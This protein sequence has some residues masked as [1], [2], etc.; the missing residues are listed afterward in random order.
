MNGPLMLL[1]LHIA[2]QTQAKDCR[3]KPPASFQHVPVCDDATYEI[4]GWSADFNDI[5]GGVGCASR[6]FRCPRQGDVAIDGCH[7]NLNS[8]SEQNRTCIAPEDAVCSL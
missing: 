8:W 5:C 3:I 2:R 1:L 7:S 6:G 4:F